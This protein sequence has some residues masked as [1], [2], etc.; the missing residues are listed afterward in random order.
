[1]DKNKILESES[2]NLENVIRNLIKIDSEVTKFKENALTERK[3]IL[4]ELPQKKKAIKE[5]YRAKAE[6][7]IEDIK[8]QITANSEKTLNVAKENCEKRI[9]RLDKLTAENSE[10]W[11]EDIF[12]RTIS[13]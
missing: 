4:T 7:H 11:I 13:N 5:Q 1:M 2:G 12:N 8:Q 3:K 10:S 6:T 9:K